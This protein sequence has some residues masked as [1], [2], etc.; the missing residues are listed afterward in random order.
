MHGG[1]LAGCWLCSQTG[2]DHLPVAEFVDALQHGRREE[3]EDK[4]SAAA[5]TAV[6]LLLLHPPGP[7]DH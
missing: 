3:A 5:A 4:V 2:G 1:W 7:S 6:A